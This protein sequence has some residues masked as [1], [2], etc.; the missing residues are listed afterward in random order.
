MPVSHVAG[1]LA[2]AVAAF[3]AQHAMALDC[4]YLFGSVA[5]GDA[6]RLSDLDLAVLFADPV[7][8]DARGELAAAL[9]G[10]LQTVEGPRVEVTV[11]ND[12]PPAVRYHVVRDG[13]LLFSADERRRVAFESRAMR[14]YLDFR[15]VL[16]R[17]DAALFARAREG[18]FAR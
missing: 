9:A 12:A 3:A 18:R 1:R 5:R 17:Y 11:L 14:E 8:E 6:G 10:H 13:R 7:G 16:A 2:R 4:V 15:P